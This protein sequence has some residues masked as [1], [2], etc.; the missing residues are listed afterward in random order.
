MLSFLSSL[1]KLQIGYLI[2]IM[3]ILEICEATFDKPEALPGY[4]IGISHIFLFFYLL[5]V[6]LEMNLKI[7]LRETRSVE[8]PFLL[9][10]PIKIE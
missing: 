6:L 7:W 2:L 5:L 4:Y 9:K 3:L 10:A 8:G 1:R